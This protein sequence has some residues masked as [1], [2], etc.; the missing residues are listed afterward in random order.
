MVLLSTAQVA[1]ALNNA[2][3]TSTIDNRKVLGLVHTGVFAD[4]GSG[5]SV[6]IALS[7]VAEFISRTRPVERDQW[8][9]QWPLFRVS[10]LELDKDEVRDDQ[11]SVLRTHMGAD[12]SGASDL[13][14]DMRELAWK[15]MWAVG[16]ETAQRAVDERAVLFG[17]T[18]GYIHPDYVAQIVG[19]RRIG[20]RV[21]WETVPVPKVVANF[22]GTGL[23]M[24]VKAGRIS[25][26]A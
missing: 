14:P 17:T 21:L 25:D 5:R 19:F 6:R 12:Y 22:V 16:D 2:F 11:D 1:E 4:R 20:A 3:G 15:G 24:P 10:L 18:K 7:D 8:P 9:D 13:P 26:W 23:W